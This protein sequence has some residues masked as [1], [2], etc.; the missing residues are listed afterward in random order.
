MGMAISQPGSRAVRVLSWEASALEPIVSQMYDLFSL[1]V[2]RERDVGFQ[3]LTPG[4]FL[5]LAEAGHLGSCGSAP[6][7]SF[8]ASPSPSKSELPDP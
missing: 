4:A 1:V 7:T 5:G 6:T 2:W 3:G 8:R